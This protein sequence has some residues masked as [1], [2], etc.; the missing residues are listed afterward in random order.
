MKKVFFFCLILIFQFPILNFQFLWA[1]TVSPFQYGLREAGSP[2]E[3]YWVLLRTHRAADS[4]GGRVSYAGIDTLRLAI[5]PDAV[6]IPLQRVN[7]F[8]GV[9]F[10][11][12]NQAKGFFLFRFT[13]EAVGVAVVDTQAVCRAI[14]GGDFR[15]HPVLGEGDWLVHIV[16]S[17]PWV[18]CRRGY[19]YGHYREDI[20]VVRD[21][22]SGDR[23]AM[24]YGAGG[25]RPTL[26]ARRLDSA[27]AGGFF[28]GGLTLMR[29]S[30]STCATWLV[31]L[32]NLAGAL[33][34]DIVAVTPQG[35]P[36]TT[37][38]ALIYIYNS[39]GV[40]LDSVTIWGT[41]S[42]PDHSGYGLLLGNLRDTRV[43]RLRSLT[44][45]GVFG[46]NNMVGTVIEDSEFNRFDI[47]CY[48][49]D[50]MFDRCLLRNGFNQ[51]SSVVGTIGFRGCTFDNFTPVYIEESYNAHT[52]FVLRMESCVWRPMARRNYIF[53]GG[54][55]ASPLNSREELRT[56]SLPD[57]EIDGLE[58]ETGRGIRRVELYHLKG[59]GR[60]ARR[61]SGAP[62]VELRGVGV[63]GNRGTKVVKS[64]RNVGF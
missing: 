26:V 5:P 59:R 13:P 8:G 33:L 49:R 53:D 43:R 21:G 35:G 51:F 19:K 16:D 50:V 15:G 24:P 27:D 20:M 4:C 46:T 52:P 42:R 17:T 10:V 62:R 38:D 31:R 41:Y 22:V 14:D 9:V 25:S 1:Q 58:I 64:N 7:D 6:S 11:V 23:P 32:E 37:G 48:G 55:V 54:P 45:W 34:R 61:Y 40:S 3:V 29:E 39:V 44:N 57:V 28:F 12:S 56:P 47:H 18:D 63:E 30:S 36:L 60:E 2:E